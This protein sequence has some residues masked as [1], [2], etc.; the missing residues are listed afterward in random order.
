[1]GV[2]TLG[3]CWHEFALEFRWFERADIADIDFRPAS[4]QQLLTEPVP[5]G[6]RTI[7]NVV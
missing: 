1:V 5:E 2:L 7:V 4:L 3:R 6:V